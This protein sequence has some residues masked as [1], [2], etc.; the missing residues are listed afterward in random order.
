MVLTQIVVHLRASLDRIR[1]DV[2]ARN[3][4]VLALFVDPIRSTE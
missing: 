3:V 1:D 4:H 2:D